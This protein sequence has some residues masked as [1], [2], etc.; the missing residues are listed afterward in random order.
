MHYNMKA[1]KNMLDELFDIKRLLSE[2][3]VRFL[4][5]KNN[6]EVR[7]ALGTRNIDLLLNDEGS[8]FTENDKPKGPGKEYNNVCPYWDLEKK[9]WRSVRIDSVITI[10][11]FNNNEYGE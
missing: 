3:T 1:I 5:E 7:E 10:L 6:G 9:A 11:E 8:G 4:Y 2:G